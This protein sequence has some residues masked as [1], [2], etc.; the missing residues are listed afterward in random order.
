MGK[1]TDYLISKVKASY[2]G[3]DVPMLDEVIELYEDIFAY[4]S[5]ELSSEKVEEDFEYL[6]TF[7]FDENNR[8]LPHFEE[9]YYHY[10]TMLDK[11]IDMIFY[12]VISTII[13]EQ[14]KENCLYQ[15]D[16][17][18][19]DK[20]IDIDY[21]LSVTDNKFIIEDND[22]INVYHLLFEDE[23][24]EL[25]DYDI[26]VEYMHSSKSLV[27]KHD[28]YNLVHDDEIINYFISSP[29]VLNYK[30]NY[31]SPK[32]LKYNDFEKITINRII[33]EALSKERVISVDEIYP[34]ISIKLNDFV[35]RNKI[36]NS[37]SLYSVLK[38]IFEDYYEFSRPIIAY[39]NVTLKNKNKFL[40]N[41]LE[42]NARTDIATF[43]K[44]MRKLSVKDSLIEMVNKLSN[45]VVFE[46]IG[47]LIRIKDIGMSDNQFNVLEENLIY[48]LQQSE[49]SVVAITQLESTY[50]FI[51]PDVNWDEWFIYSIIRKW[52]DK[53]YVG[54]TSNNYKSAVP[55]ISLSDEFDDDAL[56]FIGQYYQDEKVNKRKIIN[57]DEIELDSEIIE[58]ILRGEKQG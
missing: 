33:N 48:E 58:E 39:R 2:F 38:Y 31:L 44:Y 9:L 1:G 49:D 51:L 35:S 43:Y 18:Y 42:E 53:L 15:I 57:I 56:R 3:T 7:L 50:D 46:N 19:G 25:S 41:L 47:S 5:G 27:S 28:L 54:V 36:Y 14:I 11:D 10:D 24:D 22:D 21:C 52:S 4:K 8:A 34:E 32:N 26:L 37:Y 12:I 20:E 30:N 23:D 55:V 13:D 16:N 40:I 6:S 17:I 45:Y 29:L